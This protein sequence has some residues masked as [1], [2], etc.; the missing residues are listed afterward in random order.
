M[1]KRQR[2]QKQDGQPP[3]PTTASATREER[4]KATETHDTVEDDDINEEEDPGATRSRSLGLKGFL[5]H[6]KNQQYRVVEMRVALVCS[7]GVFFKLIYSE[8]LE[9][10]D[11]DS[12]ITHAA[13]MFAGCK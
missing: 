13:L 1:P 10:Q 11:E 4:E 3:N 9:E 5:K 7:F 8:A 12:F 6:S 2:Q